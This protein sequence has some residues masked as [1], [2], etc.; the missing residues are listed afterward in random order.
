M[1]KE[2]TDLVLKFKEAEKLLTGYERWKELTEAIKQVKEAIRE[3]EALALSKSEK[4]VKK[5]G[6]EFE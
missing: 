6:Q 5:D 2:L 4:E 1:E 3:L